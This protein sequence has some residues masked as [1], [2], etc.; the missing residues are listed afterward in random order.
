M[1]RSWSRALSLVHHG[2]EER[3]QMLD[4]PSSRPTI[5][6][7]VDS[8]RFFFDLAFATLG[9]LTRAAAV[10][11]R[12]SINVDRR[13]DD[14]LGSEPW[15]LQVLQRRDCLTCPSSIVTVVTLRRRRLASIILSST[16][17]K[18]TTRLVSIPNGKV[19]NERQNDEPLVL[20]LDA[21]NLRSSSPTL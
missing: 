6:Q 8:G 1:S 17:W 5:D 10:C 15:L 20:G 14:A 3:S 2:L 12:P 21:W 18:V 13:L 4:L 7:I 16:A 11:R 9:P 19:S